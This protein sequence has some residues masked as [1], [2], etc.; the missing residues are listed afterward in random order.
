M[1]S[2][3][4]LVLND[5]GQVVLSLDSNLAQNLTH[6]SPVTLVNNAGA[7]SSEL[8]RTQ[9][10]AGLNE[11]GSYAPPSGT[12]HLDTSTSLLNASELL[13]AA[14]KTES[15]RAIAAETVNATSVV[16][17]RSRAIAAEGSNT[18]LLNSETARATAAEQANASEISSMLATL[19]KH[20]SD[21]TGYEYSASGAGFDIKME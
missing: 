15:D 19:T 10:G 17:E 3:S 6:Y 11:D 5:Q 21:T 8:T 20:I 9:V 18:A 13:D 14:I 1:S 4:Q 16:A 2:S 7:D 12:N